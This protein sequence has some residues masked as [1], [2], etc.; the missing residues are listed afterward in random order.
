MGLMKMLAGG[1]R[2]YDEK[3]AVKVEDACIEIQEIITDLLY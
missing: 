2:F 3:T 1:S